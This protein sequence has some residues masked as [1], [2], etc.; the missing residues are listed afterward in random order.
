MFDFVHRQAFEIL[1]TSRIWPDRTAFFLTFLSTISSII[2]LEVFRSVCNVAVWMKVIHT[3]THPQT[4][5]LERNGR[6]TRGVH[7]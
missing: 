5:K 3:E 2:L 1:S 7:T 6:R 4:I